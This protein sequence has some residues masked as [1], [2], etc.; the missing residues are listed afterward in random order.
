MSPLQA[1]GDRQKRQK[2]ETEQMMTPRKQCLG[3]TTGLMHIATQTLRHHAQ[4]L[5]RVK[6]DSAEMGSGHWLPSLTKKLSA[7]G[8]RMQKKN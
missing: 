7:T 6:P 5:H 2:C 3:I 1:Q 8:T 4:G